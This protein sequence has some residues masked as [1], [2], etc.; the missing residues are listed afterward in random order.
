MYSCMHSFTHPFSTIC[1]LSIHSP[2]IIQSPN[3]VH[4]SIYL[5]INPTIIHTLSIFYPC[6]QLIYPF[7]NL[8]FNYLL[9]TTYLIIYLPI[10]PSI[11]PSSYLLIC[12]PVHSSTY[13]SPTY[14]TT[15]L[16]KHPSSIHPLILLWI[17]VSIC[18]VI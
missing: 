16:P 10:H 8:S 15:H 9:I 3:S 18:P 17:Y 2:S 4:P 5:S 1:F 7:I 6:T 13:P 11:H 14:Q 12:P